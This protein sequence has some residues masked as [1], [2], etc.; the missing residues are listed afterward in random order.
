MFFQLGSSPCFADLAGAPGGFESRPEG[1]SCC[2]VSPSPPHAVTLPSE[3]GLS[4][5]QS[6]SDNLR[7]P[8]RWGAQAGA[9]WHSRQDRG[10][11][12]AV[13]FKLNQ[14]FLSLFFLPCLQAEH[15]LSGVPVTV[16]AAHVQVSYHSLVRFVSFLG[17]LFQEQPILCLSLPV[18]FWFLFVF[19]VFTVGSGHKL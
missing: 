3:L 18:S 19:Y 6:L 12:P 13:E 5:L 10:F 15:L 17:R 4:L 2:C 9:T 1:M 8:Q 7:W 16:K 14:G 11:Y